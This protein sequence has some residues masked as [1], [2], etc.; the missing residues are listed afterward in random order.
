[1]KPMTLVFSAGRYVQVDGLGTVAG[2]VKSV[3]LK[4]FAS[5]GRAVDC[6]AS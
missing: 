6:H 3:P 5:R 4:A 2:L 1:M